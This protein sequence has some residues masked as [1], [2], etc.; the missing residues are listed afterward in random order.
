MRSRRSDEVANK[1]NVE[2]EREREREREL[3]LQLGVSHTAKYRH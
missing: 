1:I 2:R 3:R